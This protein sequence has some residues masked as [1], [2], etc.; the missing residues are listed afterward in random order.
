MTSPT[1]GSAPCSPLCAAAYARRIS[2]FPL[3]AHVQQEW[4]VKPRIMDER[5]AEGGRARPG[6]GAD[7]VVPKRCVQ[8]QGGWPE[9]ELP[10][11]VAVRGCRGNSA[12]LIG[13]REGA[14]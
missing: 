4:L 2:M 13:T 9:T 11:F 3:L 7:Q 10:G 1:L 8:R 6:I 12:P 5:R 14:D